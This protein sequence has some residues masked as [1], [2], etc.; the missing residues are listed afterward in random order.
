MEIPMKS[1]SLFA[2][3]LIAGFVTATAAR[4][5]WKSDW[6]ATVA[7]AQKEGELVVSAPS[8]SVWQTEM[9]AFEK[10]YPGIKVKMTAFS[11]RDFWPRFIK[12]REVGLYLWDFRIGG[13]DAQLNRIKAGGELQSV[14]DLLVLPEVVD[15]NAWYGGLDGCF[16][17]LD[18]KYVFGFV[19]V[20]QSSA[21]FNTRIIKEQLTAK[22]L[23]DPKW[24][25]KISMADP[26]GGSPLT[27]MGGLYRVYGSDYI[28]TLIVDQKPVITNVPR[29]QFEWLTSGRY[30]IAFG[31]PSAA[32]VD[33]QRSGGDVSFVGT[34][35]GGTQWSIGVGGIAVPT[36]NPHPNATKVFANWLLT[37]A[38]Q[39]HI[40]KGVKLN[41]RR[42]DV[43]IYAPDA[44]IDYDRY[45]EYFGGQTEAMKPYIDD[46]QKLVREL[47]KQ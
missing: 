22:D 47:V 26:R 34:L 2:A 38:T 6:D 7:A 8:G 16:M 27:T 44:A 33:Y 1:L 30:P 19:A 15:D 11:G 23:L 46:A 3:A 28:R 36:K 45:D 37:K 9:Q 24:K 17:D 43:P 40:M 25:G 41:S 21:K 13:Y 4:A 20:E 5:D 10:A 31:L 39:D 12:E 18:K 29:Q 14:R 35:T 32:V 42:K